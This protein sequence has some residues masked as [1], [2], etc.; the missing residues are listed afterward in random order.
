MAASI[1]SQGVAGGSGRRR[2]AEAALCA[3]LLVIPLLGYLRTMR[4]TFGWGDSSELTTAA[5]FLGNGHSPGY[6]TWMLIAH[7]FAR[8]PIGNVAF[9]VNFM[10]ALLGALA[11]PLLYLAFRRISGSRAAAFIAALTFAFAATFWDM[12]TEAEVYTLHI[13]FAALILLVTLRWRR[14]AVG[15]GE[16]RSDS[17][18]GDRWLFLGAWLVGISLGNH[19][20][21]A[22][23]RSST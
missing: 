4:P 23:M 22:L 1:H 18:A 16:P 15:A 7:L 5:Y 9:R 2:W 3:V 8:L 14:E 21:T 13:C 19:A 12:T 20:L 10:T 11:I 6:P 17:R